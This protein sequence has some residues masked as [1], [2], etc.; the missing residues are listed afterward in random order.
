MGTLPG[1]GPVEPLMLV[2][3]LL[4]RV[5]SSWSFRFNEGR[6]AEDLLALQDQDGILG[7]SLT[8]QARQDSM[9]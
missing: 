6:I 8:M 7:E 1:K 2:I 3:L 5:C 4:S 9:E